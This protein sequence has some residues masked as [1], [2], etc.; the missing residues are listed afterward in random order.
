MTVPAGI[1]P[2]DPDDPARGGHDSDGNYIPADPVQKAGEPPV[3]PYTRPPPAPKLPG[4][5][6]YVD[7]VTGAV[8]TKAG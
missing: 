1:T 3:A 8:T 4:E 2:I 5:V 6:G 7:P